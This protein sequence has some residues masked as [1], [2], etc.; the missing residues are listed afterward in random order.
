MPRYLFHADNGAGY[1]EDGEGRD[2]PDL[3]TARRE[4]LKSAGE[5]IAEELALGR[6]DIKLIIY[7]AA[8]SGEPLAALPVSVSVAG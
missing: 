2:L 8:E 5:I 4:A 3:A 6:T 1:V 7:I